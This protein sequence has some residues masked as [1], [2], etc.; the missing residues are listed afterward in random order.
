M[1]AHPSD[2]PDP[3]DL[4]DLDALAEALNQ[5]S[6][7][8]LRLTPPGKTPYVDT[9]QPQS[10][11]PGIRIYA[12]AGNYLWPDYRP[13]AP[14]DHPTAAAGIIAHQLRTTTSQHPNTP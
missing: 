10:M 1:P 8:S 3:A 6:L 12:Q 11:T 13:I 5:L 7:P 9:G 4:A 14:T 2:L